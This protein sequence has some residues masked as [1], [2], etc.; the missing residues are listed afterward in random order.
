MALVPDQK[1]S[2]F[3]AGGTPTTGD[4]IVGLRGGINT[5]F[6]W[7][8]PATIDSITGTLNQILVNGSAGIPVTGDVTLTTPQDIGTSSSPTFAN[9]TLG[10]ASQIRGANGLPVL[11][12]LSLASAVNSIVASN[13]ISGSYPA[14][15]A[16][17]SD[18]DVGISF[19]A[20]AA[21]V[22]TFASTATAAVQY[23][24]GTGYQHVTNFIFPNTSA[25]RNVTFQ[26]ASGTLAYL[27][28]LG[29]YVQSVTGTANQIDVDNT[30][31][32]NPVL[33]L[34]STLIAPGTAQVGN[35]LLDTNTISVTNSNGNLSLLPNGTGKILFD[36]ST[37]ITIT[38]LNPILQYNTTSGGGFL[39]SRFINSAASPGT[40]Y[41]K[42]RGATVGSLGAVQSGDL[43]GVQY[44]YADDG[45]TYNTL[46][47]A[48]TVEVLGTVSTGIVPTKMTL[49]TMNTSGVLNASLSISPAGV[50]TLFSPLP[51]ASGGL[52]INTTP[53]NGQ[54]PIG[55]GTNYTVA[56]I[57]AGTGITVTNGSG[58][59]TIAANA[60]ALVTSITGTAN[61]VLANGTS[62]SAQVGAI[63][64]TLPQDIG[65][66]S[67]PTFAGLTLSSPLTGANGG[68]GI[69]NGTKTIT[70]GG[71]LTTSGAFNST[72]TM[73]NT[74]S[75]TFP[76]SGTLATTAQIPTGAALTKTDDTNVTLTLGGSPTTALVNAASLTLGWT[77]QLGL[78]RGGT[79]ASLTA[80]NGGIV[81]STA[82]AMAI[83]SG[84]ATANQVLLSG[85]SAAPAWSTATYPATTTINQIL[86]SS[87]ANT[88]TGLA[89][90]NSSVLVTNGSGVPS[91]STTLPS[92]LA[93]TNMTLTTPTLGVA[94]ATSINFGGG[95]LS[96][97]VP[98]TA[99]TP[100]LTFATVG[101]LSVSYAT[102][103]GLYERIGNVVNYT[104]LLTCTPTFTTAAGALRIAGLPLTVLTGGYIF[105]GN[106]VNDGG[107]T[108]TGTTIYASP[109]GNQTYIQIQTT[110]SATAEGT[111][112]T[113]ALVSG[114]AI[115]FKIF[116][117]Y[118]V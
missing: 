99:F 104:I 34:P 78:T 68:T 75:V 45:S 98:K 69:N 18:T 66:G 1:F 85:S 43:V 80:S 83:L 103:V 79:A 51:V 11:T 62:G 10:G 15:T 32:Q 44:F 111:L 60:A 110:K 65:T 61:Q 52:G 73:T 22:Y 90:A 46:S 38:G 29:G 9:I 37:S 116:G 113:T 117:S 105:Y 48:L 14:L 114:V 36:T 41:L 95:A 21:G 35:I 107:L 89:T 71:N 6:N 49:S 17:G 101:D 64:L 109:V 102:Q 63:T 28:D 59:I 118:F 20:Q 54:I 12:V 42:S 84:T 39:Q 31:P 27:S 30:D 106:I 77:G 86:Y 5:K 25:T 57:T 16:F 26:D 76:T 92:G 88:V 97:Y 81:Y 67:S 91:L 19:V 93:A 70:L 24:T 2:T 3:Q 56:T 8:L 72:F 82:S 115:T 23:R 40:V 96:S 112:A 58:S 74:T 100:T 108:Y 7:T 13:Q 4:I 47:G 55:N 50:V 87:A 94:S 33:S 53:S